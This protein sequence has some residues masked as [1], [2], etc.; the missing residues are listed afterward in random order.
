MHHKH[1]L[2]M[3]P[4]DSK[5]YILDTEEDCKQCDT[6]LQELEN[7]DDEAEEAGK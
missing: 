4:F 2:I 7:I 5:F 1:T 3:D 6:V